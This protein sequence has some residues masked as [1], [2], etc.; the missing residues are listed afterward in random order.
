MDDME[1]DTKYVIHYIGDT[2]N[3]LCL[4]SVFFNRYEVFAS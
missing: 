1:Q 4:I 2:I 3:L